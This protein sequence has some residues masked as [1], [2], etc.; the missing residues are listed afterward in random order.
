LRLRSRCEF[1]L[2][3]QRALS[4]RC[5]SKASWRFDQKLIDEQD[6]KDENSSHWWH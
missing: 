6:F 1:G 2:T 3:L 4:H 5:A